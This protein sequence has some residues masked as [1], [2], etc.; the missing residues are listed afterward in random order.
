M[1]DKTFPPRGYS[2]LA[3]IDT[4]GPDTVNIL[5]P[6]GGGARSNVCAAIYYLPTTL[7]NNGV[8]V[9]LRKRRK[10]EESNDTV[11]TH[12]RHF[13]IFH[14]PP[15]FDYLFFHELGNNDQ[16]NYFNYFSNESFSSSEF[17]NVW[18]RVQIWDAWK[19][20]DV[21]IRATC[22]I[23]RRLIWNAWKRERW[24]LVRVDPLGAL[25]D[26]WQRKFSEE[27][28][29][30]YY[31]T[32]VFVSFDWDIF[33]FLYTF[34]RIIIYKKVSSSNCVKIRGIWEN[35]EK[36]TFFDLITL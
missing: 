22:V 31:V 32:R 25:R 13:R 34:L 29:K 7:R 3:G 17:F 15:S 26:N 20:R 6:G 1:H 4:S 21:N 18:A 10:F 23:S 27:E 14:R 35:N 11:V 12:L 9:D 2:A 16:E 36:N 28:E 24:K 33:L 19:F 8:A 30:L 5:K